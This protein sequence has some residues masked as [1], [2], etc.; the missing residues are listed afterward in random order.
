M[1]ERREMV[2]KVEASGRGERRR[3]MWLIG[4]AKAAGAPG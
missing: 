3:G 1:R 2:V 4:R